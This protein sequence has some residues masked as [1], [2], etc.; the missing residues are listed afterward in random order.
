MSTVSEV[1]RVPRDCETRAA[2]EGTEH[3][4]WVPQSGQSMS[5]L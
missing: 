3:V 4:Q 5:E 1:V 2:T